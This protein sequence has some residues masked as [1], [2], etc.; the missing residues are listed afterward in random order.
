MNKITSVAFTAF[1]TFA[2]LWCVILMVWFLLLVFG[3]VDLPPSMAH[4]GH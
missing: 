2:V 1:M 3:V 4:G